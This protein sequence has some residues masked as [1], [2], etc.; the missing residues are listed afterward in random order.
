MLQHLHDFS[1]L[2]LLGDEHRLE[3]LRLLMAGPQ[4]LSSLGKTLGQH[5][6]QVRHHLK[7]LESA[8]LV[9]LVETRLVGG[10]VE[11]YYQ[12][13]ARAF[14]FHEMIL[15]AFAGLEALV[16][17][18]S[19][20]LAWE[21]LAQAAS[22]GPHRNRVLSLPVGSLDGLVA[23]RQGLAQIAGIH[24]LDLESG[25]YNLPF[26]RRFFPDRPV[27][28]YTLAHREQGLL[29]QPGNPLGLR[30]LSDLARPGLTFINRKRGSGTRLWL[31]RALVESGLVPDQIIGYAN[32]VDTHTE[33]AL[34]V[35][36]GRAQAALA[37]HAAAAHF[38]LGFIPLF[39]ERY[40]LV[41]PREFVH[42]PAL[43]PLLD[44]LNSHQ[45]QRQAGQLTG[46]DTHHSGEHLTL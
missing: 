16:F 32:E 42:T 28:V 46:Y 13:R 40:D 43:Q 2:K 19:H 41:I 45:F 25:E 20:D 10:Y 24:L 38:N 29:V 6:A 35:S 18:G 14:V 1:H 17:L 4:T 5:P 12:A 8:A 44:L 30:Q 27:E 33:A 39:Q 7:K 37:L 31:D 9:E 21:S 36:H 34:A 3:I 23:L 15:P 11:K 26:V 22:S